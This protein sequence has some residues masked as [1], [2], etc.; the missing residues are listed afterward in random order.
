MSSDCFR[1]LFRLNAR[2]RAQFTGNSLSEEWKETN[3]SE[4]RA[5]LDSVSPGP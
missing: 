3:W 1:G 5:H 4:A 2:R